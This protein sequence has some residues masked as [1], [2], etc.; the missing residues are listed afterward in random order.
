MRDLQPVPGILAPDPL[1]DRLSWGALAG[2]VRGQPVDEW[3]R[4]HFLVARSA[5]TPERCSR[6]G[7]R[8]PEVCI[9]PDQPAARAAV[10]ALPAVAV[11]EALQAA[12]RAEGCPACTVHYTRFSGTLTL[13]AT[14]W[15]VPEAAL[16]GMLYDW[17]PGSALECIDRLLGAAT[18]GVLGELAVRGADFVARTIDGLL[19][20]DAARAGRQDR[21]AEG[22]ALL[23]ELT[24]SLGAE[25]AA[26]ICG[27][28]SED[29][30][31][32]RATEWEAAL[33]VSGDR[34]AASEAVAALL[35]GWRTVLSVGGRRYRVERRRAVR[36][37]GLM[38]PGCIVALRA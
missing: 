29:G 33:R 10:A 26:E 1:S 3:K 25:L 20:D 6:L 15:G 34:Q 35:A 36:L 13:S 4:G 24:E 30:P 27:D 17:L 5:L 9:H 19:V 7:I 31:T 37:Q 16:S 12:L 18:G 14:G 32:V 28:L 22:A 2:R 23:A 8:L 21:L 11:S 38:V